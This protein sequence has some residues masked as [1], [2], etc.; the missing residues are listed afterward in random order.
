MACPQIPL[1]SPAP[2][3]C[4]SPMHSIDIATLS[5]R[6]Q[7]FTPPSDIT[8]DFAPSPDLF[9]S[10]SRGVAHFEP[11]VIDTFAPRRD[12]AELSPTSSMSSSDASDSSLTFSPEDAFFATRSRV[13]RVSGV[14][15]HCCFIADALQL[16][17]LPAMAE[18]F[19]SAVFL[20]H[21]VR[22]SAILPSARIYN[23]K[24]VTIQTAPVTMWELTDEFAAGRRDSVWAVFRTHE[25]V[26]CH[27]HGINEIIPRISREPFVL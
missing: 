13:V 17:N 1:W 6:L 16:S 14:R 24:M 22:I 5:D 10:Y 19:L 25:E 27:V 12:M 20:P 8:S 11:K 4:L 2:S 21:N 15:P 18:S 7:R 9:V 3:R 26:S 23:L